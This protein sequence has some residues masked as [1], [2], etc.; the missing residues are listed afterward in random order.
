MTTDDATND[1]RLYFPVREGWAVHVKT[2]GEKAYCYAKRT[3]EDF[4]HAIVRGELFVQRDHE[5]FCIECALQH[6]FLTSDR[7]FWQRRSP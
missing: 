6:G 5:K 3:G 7:L 4:Y 1:R 2:D